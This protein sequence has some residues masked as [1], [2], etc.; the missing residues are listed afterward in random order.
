[1]YYRYDSAFYLAILSVDYLK[2]QR[3]KDAL[4]YYKSFQ[5]A[6]PNTDKM[7]DANRM[8]EQLEQELSTFTTKS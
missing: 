4:S 3:L 5:K 8:K 7:E 1:M 6:F 2:E